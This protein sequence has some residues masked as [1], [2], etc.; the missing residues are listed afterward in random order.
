MRGEESRETKAEHHDGESGV[1]HGSVAASFCDDESAD[2]SEGEE[3]HECG[4]NLH[5]QARGGRA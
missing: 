3:D 2:N 1:V 4:Q 5:L